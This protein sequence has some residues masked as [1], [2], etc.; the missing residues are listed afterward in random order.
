LVQLTYGISW[1]YVIGDVAWEG[2]KARTHRHEDPKTV[3]GLV[4]ER[5]IFQSIASMLIPM[6]LIHTQVSVFQKIISRCVF[7]CFPYAGKR[8]PKNYG[9]PLCFPSASHPYSFFQSIASMLTPMCLIHTQVT[10]SKK[11]MV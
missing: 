5:A 1:T 10:G 8:V 11:M 2:Y 3:A 9:D 4:L 7:F 6:C